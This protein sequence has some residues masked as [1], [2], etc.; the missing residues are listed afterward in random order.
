MERSSAAAAG[1]GDAGFDQVGGEFGFGAFEG[2]G[3]GVDDLA[4]GF[5]EGF[6]DFLGGDDALARQAGD[7]VA[8]ADLH[9]FFPRQLG[10]R[11]RS[12]S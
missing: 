3:D 10:R 11:S 8:A 1:E 9:G 6:A 12:R 2:A 5:L 4:D 7:H